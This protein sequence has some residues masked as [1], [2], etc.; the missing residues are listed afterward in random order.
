[1]KIIAK[2]D[3]ASIKQILIIILVCLCVVLT[4]MGS[5]TGLSFSL[6]RCEKEGQ[7]SVQV[8]R[9][10]VTALGPNLPSNTL[11]IGGDNG[12]TVDYIIT[13]DNENSD[14]A[15]KYNVL[16][17]IPQGLPAGITITI[18]GNDGITTDRNNFI[19]SDVGYFPAGEKKK[20]QNKITFSIV[21][22]EI[23]PMLLSSI[24]VSVQAEQM[25]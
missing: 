11:L 22:R 5:I 3:K 18:D 6:M 17:K 13:V 4:L 23:T 9:F 25:D 12:T 1:M 15:F 2:R 16:V 14:V 8:A 24:T 7:D 21:D 19:F 10:N 20:I